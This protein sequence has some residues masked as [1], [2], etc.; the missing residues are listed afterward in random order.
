MI[1]FAGAVCIFALLAGSVG[2]GVRVPVLSF[3]VLA[4]LLGG[5]AHGFLYPAL[6]AL[7]VDVTPEARRASAV[8]IF[9]AVCLLG[10]AVGAVA[11]G[12]IAHGVGYTPMWIA[13]AVVMAG[14][15]VASFRLAPGPGAVRAA[16]SPSI[17]RAAPGAAAAELRADR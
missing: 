6:S 10:N 15:I 11:F 16:E 5:G 1:I 7:L 13:L 12:Y 3:I 17:A 14:G 8:G 9:S 4:G 2:P